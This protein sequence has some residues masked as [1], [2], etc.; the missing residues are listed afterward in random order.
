MVHLA[1][2][3]PLF[4]PDHGHIVPSV[5][6][7]AMA[8]MQTPDKLLKDTFCI[9]FKKDSADIYFRCSILPVIVSYNFSRSANCGPLTLQIK[10]IVKV[11]VDLY[12]ALS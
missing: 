12:S 7:G 6:P 9:S 4:I 8:K 5:G 3:Q 10:V 11:N 1:S 2:Q